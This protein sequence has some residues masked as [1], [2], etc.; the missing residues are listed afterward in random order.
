METERTSAATSGTRRRRR[1]DTRP[2]LAHAVCDGLSGALILALAIFTPWAFGTTQP[3]SLRLADLGGVALGV[4]LVAKWVIRAGTGYRPSRWSHGPTGESRAGGPGGGTGRR[5]GFDGP[6]AALALGTGLFLALVATSYVNARADFGERA[7]DL[8]Y[9]DS[10]IRWLP[11]SYDQGRTGQW[12]AHVVALAGVFWGVRDWLSTRTERD[13]REERE[14]EETARGFGP[15]VGEHPRVPFPA[16]LRLLLWVLCLN[17]ALLA[18]EGG[19]QRAAGTNKLLF[20]VEPRAGRRVDSVYGPWSYRSSAGQ[21]FNLLWPLCIGFWVH[22][23]ERVSRRNPRR[24][25]WLEGPQLAI[26]PATMALIAGSAV[27][28]SRGAALVSGVLGLGTVT[29]LLAGARRK[30]DGGVRRLAATWLAIAGFAGALTGGSL[31]WERWQRGDTE[32]TTWIEVG[33]GDCSILMKVRMPN[34]PQ[35]ANQHLLA[36]GPFQTLREWYP[37]SLYITLDREGSLSVTLHGAS[38][39]EMGWIKLP[40]FGRRFGGREILLA[41]TRTDT[42]GVS[43]DGEPQTWG[44]NDQRPPPTGWRVPLL[45]D[46]CSIRYPGI[47]EA[48]IGRLALAPDALRGMTARSSLKTTASP[49]N[50]PGARWFYWTSGFDWRARFG[51]SG[52]AGRTEIWR[53]AVRIAADHPVWGSGLGSFST[54]YELYKNPRMAWAAYAHDDWLEA[55]VT[56]GWVGL[57]LIVGL[58]GSLAWRLKRNVATRSGGWRAPDTLIG[59]GTLSLAGCLVHARFDLPFQIYSVLFLF[60]LVAGMLAGLSFGGGGGTAEPRSGGAEPDRSKG[61][62]AEHDGA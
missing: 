26:I 36:L 34:A 8:T 49:A 37:G 33:S 16:R 51:G 12:L 5:F 11:H 30:A 32:A 4:L 55:R 7:G 53:V 46:Q 38:R 23:Q 1:A 27:A 2:P 19:L 29:L 57:G 28:G 15:V 3:W 18:I 31:L 20:L 6:T 45:P 54:V 17:G 61:A 21:Y 13:R 62:L 25:A 48:A 9:F 42:L 24:T 22:L 39:E 56:V 60:V 52:L 10:F 50:G 47:L 35:S 59:L 58:L 44:A 40:D 41:I 14:E 43:V